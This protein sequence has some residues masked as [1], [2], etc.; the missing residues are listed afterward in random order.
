MSSPIGFFNAGTAAL[1]AGELSTAVTLLRQ[2]ASTAEDDH[3]ASAAWKNLGIALR[4]SGEDDQALEAFR[5]A[6]PRLSRY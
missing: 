4:R 6:Q 3:L 2:A 1:R 5:C